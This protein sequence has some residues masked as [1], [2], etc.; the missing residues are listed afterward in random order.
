MELNILQMQLFCMKNLY[1]TL[2]ITFRTQ[3]VFITTFLCQVNTVNFNSK[4]Y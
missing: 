4:K 3:V 2:I 1:I